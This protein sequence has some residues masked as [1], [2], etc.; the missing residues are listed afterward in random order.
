MILAVEVEDR[1]IVTVE[2]LKN[3]ELQRAFLEEAGFQCGFCTPGFLLNSEALLT[4]H[5]TPS[6][7]EMVRWLSSNLCRCTGYESIEQAVRAVIRKK[8]RQEGRGK[9]EPAP[10]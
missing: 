6:D 4:A 2:G 1:D 9:D 3:R 8:S 5:P 7:E 10:E